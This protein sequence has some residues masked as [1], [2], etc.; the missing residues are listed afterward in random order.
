MLYPS[1]SIPL[2]MQL[3]NEIKR[4]IQSGLYKVDDALP[5]ERRLMELYGVSRMTVRQAVGNLVSEG[6][7]HRIHGKGTFVSRVY[8][9][10]PNSMAYGLVEEL[11][12]LHDNIDIEL[13]SSGYSPASKEVAHEL[14]MHEGEEVFHYTR[15]ITEKGKPILV[16][17]SYI[18][19]TLSRL[20]EHLNIEKTVV[21]DQLDAYGYRVT[22]IAQRSK[23]ALPNEHEASLLCIDKTE[24]VLKLVRTSYITGRVPIIFTQAVY[25]SSYEFS[26][27]LTR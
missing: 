18:A 5:G 25:S 20:I 15:R 17:V 19:S 7:L 11:R 27:N 1:S 8:D 26:I 24:P 16:T 9:N 10:R 13:V 6:L 3:E 12:L 4:N 14:K 21:Y 23:A 2:Y 22:Q